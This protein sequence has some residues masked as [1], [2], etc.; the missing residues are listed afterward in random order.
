MF[1]EFSRRHF[2]KLAGFRAGM[3]ATPAKSKTVTLSLYLTGNARV[4]SVWGNAT[5]AY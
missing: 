5:S 2:A 4:A 1:D 3:A